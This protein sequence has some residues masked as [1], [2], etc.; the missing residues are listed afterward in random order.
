MQR[1]QFIKALGGI[2]AVVAAD[3]VQSIKQA[4]GGS[5]KPNIILRSGWQ[6]INIGDIAHSPG[7]L[8]LLRQHIPEASIYF[9][10]V[11]LDDNVERMINRNF[12]KVTILKSSVDSNGLPKEESVKATFL[13][14]NLLIHGSGAGVYIHDTLWACHE[15]KIPYGIFGVT[16]SSI[17]ENL[18]KILSN[19]AFIFCRETKSIQNLKDAGISGPI[20]GFG[21]DGTFALNI[22]DEAR[23]EEYLQAK[24]LHKKKFICVVPRLRYT[25]YHRLRKVNWSE[26]KVKEVESTNA[27]TREKDHAKLRQAITTWVRETGNKVLVCPEMTYQIDIIEPLVY[28]PLPDDVKKSVVPKLDF[29]LP[30]EA[31]SIY[32]RAF[33][34]V[35]IECH[36]PILSA[37][38]GTPFFYVRQPEDTI[39]GQ[40]YYDLGFGDW[41][42]EIDEVSG[43]DISN[44]VMKIHADYKAALQ[45]VQTGLNEAHTKQAE[46]MQKAKE[47]L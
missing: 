33:M 5:R 3:W 39:K 32:K 34:V 42:Y 46:G 47:I 23:A 18:R 29:W 9:W 10:P 40:M 36:S 8:M 17:N 20:V 4:F 35:S 37:T 31:S 25:P 6:N 2:T 22:T 1:R 19:A 38:Q 45:L 24:G 44:G 30:D 13:K 28:G 26:E 43:K 7:L 21:P 41:V 12:P 14:A 11:S 27:A 15:N 16:V